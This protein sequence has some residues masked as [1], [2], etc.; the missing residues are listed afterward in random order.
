M[1][2][3]AL[4]RREQ[5]AYPGP[6]P[7]YDDKLEVV[8]AMGSLVGLRRL[9]SARHTAGYERD[10]RLT[11][12]YIFG[13]RWYLDTCGNT[14]RSN[15]DPMPERFRVLLPVATN[16][17]FWKFLADCR[18]KAPEVEESLSFGMED[19]IP[20]P[21]L[22]CAHCGLTWTIE[23]AYDSTVRHSTEVFPLHRFV[24]G[25]LGEVVD[26]YARKTDAVYR[27]QPDIMLRNDKWIDLSPKYPEPKQDWEKRI[28]VNQR[29]WRGK[30][31]G[32]DDDAFIGDGDEAFFNVWKY[33]HRECHGASMEESARN[34]FCEMLSTSGFVGAQ[35]TPTPNLY[36]SA[37]YR[38]PWFN[39]R[40]FGVDI[41][42]GWRKRVIEIEWGSL[43]VS[44]QD[45]V[46]ALFVDEETTH[47]NTLVHA[48]GRDHGVSCLTRICGVLEAVA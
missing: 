31:D 8:R 5:P 23:N 13:G 10:E 47:T 48:N 25:R 39:V 7:W 1:Q 4:G 14:M 32:I 12:F 33:Y 24:N 38:G 37:S 35:L 15:K 29:G 9:M 11:E 43:P 3:F 28:V 22:Q 40:A 26:E 42:I 6:A 19:G 41:R 20:F 27:M 16:E 46:A 36:G 34:E 44:T 30:K 45:R 2:K 17:E 18:N 21:G